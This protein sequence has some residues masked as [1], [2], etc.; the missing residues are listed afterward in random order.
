[1]VEVNI[2]LA[3]ERY[4]FILEILQNKTTVRV[5]HLM[6][7]L[8]VS[9]ETIRRDLEY[10]EKEG[11][12][13]RVY[14][15]ASTVKFDTNQ[16]SFQ[17]RASKNIG[18]K[19]EI[20]KFALK[21]VSEGQSI[22]LD[23]S[24]TSLAFA[25]ELKN[26]FKSLTIVTNSS[27]ILNEIFDVNTFNIIFCGGLFNHCELSFFGEQ[28]KAVINGLNIDTAFIGVGGI[29][30]REGCTET[31]YEG[32]EMLRNFINAAQRKIVLVDSSKFDKVTLI[33]VCDLSDIDMIITDSSIKKNVLD[34]YRNH[35]IEVINE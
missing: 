31:F 30:L 29:S 9:G 16:G 21:Y 3:Q 2:M 28:A 27:E 12:L 26:H 19:E 13:T 10:L 8:N 23:Y 34:K 17:A 4:N 24:T 11:H 14:G 25:H 22:S 5:S 18:Q 15:G 7:A 1:M 35:D 20:A 6:H 32:A 33:K